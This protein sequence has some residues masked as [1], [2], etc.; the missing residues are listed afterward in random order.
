MKS[1]WETRRDGSLML[2]TIRD[3]IW[4]VL[5]MQH[6]TPNANRWDY[7]DI[8]GGGHKQVNRLKDLPR[9]T[10]LHGCKKL[11]TPTHPRDARFGVLCD[12]GCRHRLGDIL[13]WWWSVGWGR[14]HPL[15]YYRKWWDFGVRPRPTTNAPVT[16]HAAAVRFGG[17]R[18]PYSRRKHATS[19]MWPWHNWDEIT[20]IVL[21]IY[22]TVN[23]D[24]ATDTKCF[25]FQICWF[26]F[27]A[28]TKQLY[29]WLS[30][31]VC[32]SVCLSVTP[33]SLCSRHSIIMKFSGVITNDRRSR[34]KVKGQGQ[35]GHNP[36]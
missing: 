9:G 30:P 13:R 27:L 22:N 16:Y 20:V 1:Y 5:N 35:R 14:T 25:F 7:S 2:T 17:L 31:S 33:F 29:E 6:I 28:A 18:S 32:P 3:D 34:L 11:P 19:Y 10:R 4:N 12:G 23:K 21:H 24:L 15:G 26:T 36:T 8:P